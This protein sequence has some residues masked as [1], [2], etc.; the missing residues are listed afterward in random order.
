MGKFEGHPSPWEID[1]I[2][3]T[4]FY[5]N[6]PKAV[7]KRLRKTSIYMEGGTVCARVISRGRLL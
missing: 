1:H 6:A 2:Y 5:W 3:L 7:W 4:N